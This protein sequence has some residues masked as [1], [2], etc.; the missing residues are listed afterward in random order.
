MRAA[1]V[2]IA[3]TALA[4]V[5]TGCSS[6]NQEWHRDCVIE[7][8]ERLISQGTSA[9][10]R[11]YTSC[12]SFVVNDSIA[13]GYSSQDRFNQLVEGRTYDLQTGDYRIGLLSSFPNVIDVK[14]K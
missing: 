2:V 1:R 5:L 6:M 4:V 8:K 9:T 3:A 7:S 10:K 11:V 12:G 13:G 14:P